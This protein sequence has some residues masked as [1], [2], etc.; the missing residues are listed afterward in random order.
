VCIVVPTPGASPNLPCLIPGLDL[1]V[2]LGDLSPKIILQVLNVLAVVKPHANVPS[3]L[4]IK[5]CG[6]SSISGRMCGVCIVF[7]KENSRG[8]P[9]LLFYFK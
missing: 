8:I 1:G 5:S 9:Y 3:C 6:I 4:Q 2:S 7:L